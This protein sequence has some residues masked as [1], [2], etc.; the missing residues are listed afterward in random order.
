M[1]CTPYYVAAVW[2]GFDQPERMYVSGNPAAQIFKKIMRPIHEGLA[3]K[4]FPWP[5][6]GGDTGIFGDLAE[7]EDPQEEF[8]IDGGDDGGGYVPPPSTPDDGGSGGEII[9]VG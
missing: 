4:D 8:I 1:G 9:I 5:Y 3:W 6:I 2:T 7:E